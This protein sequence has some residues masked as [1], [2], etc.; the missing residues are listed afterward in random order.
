MRKL[1]AVMTLAVAVL[2]AYADDVRMPAK[3]NQVWQEECGSCHLAFPPSLL[4]AKDWRAMMQGLDKH[5]GVNA[6][7]DEPNRLDI[8]A[9]L[10]ANAARKPNKASAKSLRITETPWFVR[11]HDEVPTRLWSDPRVNSAANCAACHRDAERGDYDEDGIRM[12]GATA[13]ST[14]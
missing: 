10:E 8:L 14:R 2:P 9:F 13:R 12:P 3:P 7:L 4:A 11:E 1:I 6:T 5:F